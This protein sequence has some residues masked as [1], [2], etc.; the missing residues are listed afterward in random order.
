MAWACSTDYQAWDY[1]RET[2]GLHTQV[3]TNQRSLKFYNKPGHASHA[4]KLFL[5]A[6][7]RV[8]VLN[9]TPVRVLWSLSMILNMASALSLTAACSRKTEKSFPGPENAILR[10]DDDRLPGLN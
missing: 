6:C 10:P 4:G 9:R 8:P 5:L 3:Q 1:G 7:V 2:G